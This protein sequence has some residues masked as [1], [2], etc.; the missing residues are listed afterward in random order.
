MAVRL[1][2]EEISAQAKKL[3]RG[4]Y[5]RVG[6]VKRHVEYSRW[7]RP[8]ARALNLEVLFLLIRKLLPLKL[9]GGGGWV[10]C[11]TLGDAPTSVSSTTGIIASMR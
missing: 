3:G 1:E 4:I 8:P 2:V 7:A 10:S 5:N 9:G 6:V 11:R